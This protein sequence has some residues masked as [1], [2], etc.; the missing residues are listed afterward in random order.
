MDLHLQAV[1]DA[2]S[3]VLPT[4]VWRLIHRLGYEHPLQFDADRARYNGRTWLALLNNLRSG[5][6]WG[7]AS[8]FVTWC[9]GADGC[10]SVNDLR[11]LRQGLPFEVHIRIQNQLGFV[12]WAHIRCAHPECSRRQPGGPCL[13]G[14][15]RECIQA[16]SSGSHCHQRC[17]NVARLALEADQTCRLYMKFGLSRCSERVDLT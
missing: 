12:T 10:P 11:L 2:L 14:C 8:R 13:E 4:D 3:L 16:S 6:E 7:Y 15:S 9:E 1:E 5:D 17:N